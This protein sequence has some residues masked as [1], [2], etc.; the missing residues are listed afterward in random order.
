VTINTVTRR[1]PARPTRAA[2]GSH[3]TRLAGH[4]DRAGYGDAASP[5][6]TGRGGSQDAAALLC[7]LPVHQLH[8]SF[9]QCL[10]ALPGPCDG[11]HALRRDPHVPGPV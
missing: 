8:R 10:A 3:Q 7:D 11:G 1:R 5:S 9:A 2:G 4:R 6:M